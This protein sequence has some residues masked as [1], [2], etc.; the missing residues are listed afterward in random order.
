MYYAFLRSN[1]PLSFGFQELRREMEEYLRRL[2]EE[3][4]QAKR[5]GMEQYQV[6]SGIRF[7]LGMI[8]V[9]MGLYT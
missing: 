2:A 5:W 7:I 3:E 4:E 8:Q 9:L 6:I 1:T